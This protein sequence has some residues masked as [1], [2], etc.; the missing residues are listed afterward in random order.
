MKTQVWYIVASVTNHHNNNSLFEMV[1]RC[2]DSW[3]INTMRT[4]HNVISTLPN[5]NVT[6]LFQAFFQLI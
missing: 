6:P 4:H 5:I 3:S 1:L 2:L